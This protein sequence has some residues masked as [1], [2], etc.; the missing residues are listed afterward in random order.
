MKRFT[1]KILLP[2]LFLCAVS[3][4]AQKPAAAPEA[5]KD[6]AACFAAWDAN[7][8]TLQTDFVQTTEYDGV[9][10]S[11]SAGRIYYEKNG[12]KLRLDN[13]DDANAVTQTALT[14][15]KQIFVLDEKGKEISTLSWND[16]LRGQP[17]Q[18]LFDFGN[19]ASL[20]SRHEAEEF[21]RTEGEV[22][23]LLKP[24]DAAQSYALYVAVGKK[25]CF[26]R[27]ITVRSELM[28]TTAELTGKKLNAAL[29]KD[30]FKGLKK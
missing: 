15:K 21:E 19:Y 1:N 14:D 7:M 18:A 3:A 25:D 27:R 2:A 5:K 20:L 29:K 10:I 26:P 9:L 16:W 11:R 17:N 12:P 8:H 30:I 23:L 24:K 28:S 4:A 22:I 13:V 6:Y